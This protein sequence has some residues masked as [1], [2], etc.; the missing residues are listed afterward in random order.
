MEALILL[1]NIK[2]FS[3][4]FLKQKCGIKILFTNIKVDIIFSSLKL[5]T[6]YA[7]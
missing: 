6:F 3:R 4:F 7:L 2:Y 1:N 5:V